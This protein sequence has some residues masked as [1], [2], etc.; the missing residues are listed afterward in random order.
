MEALWR[1]MRVYRS[2]K[3]ASINSLMVKSW[4]MGSIDVLQCRVTG[5]ARESLEMPREVF[6]NI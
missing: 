6:K 3:K 4:L 1:D 2:E 5:V